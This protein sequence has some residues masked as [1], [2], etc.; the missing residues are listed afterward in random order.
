[1]ENLPRTTLSHLFEDMDDPRVVG[2]CTYPLVEVVL[3]GIC[4]VLCG[5]ETW[6]E[7]EEFGESKH[8]WLAQFLK[9]AQ[10]IP[11]HDTF[12]R[13]FSLLPAEV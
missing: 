9:L 3:I 6:T 1:M 2:R 4:A 13:V 5:A 12:R 7:V 10:G 11:S 8:A